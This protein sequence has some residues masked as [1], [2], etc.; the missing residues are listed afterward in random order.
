MCIA[1]WDNLSS[2][3]QLRD[4]PDRVV[5]WNRFQRDEAVRLHGMPDE[6]IV[7]T[8]A[9]SFDQWFD[10]A[11]GA[12][13][14]FCA[15]VGL[16]PN[17]PYVLF[18]GGALFPGTQT[19][20]EYVRQRLDP[21]ASRATRGWPS[22]QV[23]VRPHPRRS[24]A[25]G[26][27]ALRPTSPALPS[28]RRRIGSRCRSTRRRAPT[29]STRSPTATAVVGINTTAM[30]EAAA[31]GRR[32]VH[33]VLHPSFAD[34]QRDTYHFDYLL[35]VGGGIVRAPRRRR[36]PR[37][38]GGDRWQA[39]TTT[40]WEERRRRF[41]LEFVRPHGLDQRGAAARPR[42][43]SRKRQR[44]GPVPRPAR[45]GPACPRSGSHCRRR[46]R[47]SAALTRRLKRSRPSV[48]STLALG[49]DAASL[50]SG[51]VDPMQNEPD[52]RRDG[53][54]D[55]RDEQSEPQQPAAHAE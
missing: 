45:F 50:P 27:R 36:A 38:A 39:T 43:R 22:V 1:S 48:G 52:D 18:V 46:R 6:R 17:R 19:E 13:E 10:R 7:V 29:S 34:S 2:K 9:Q 32:S 25:V 37:A 44:F 30:I 41:L 15:R 47:A 14:E 51:S 11:P 5:V 26:G 12:R 23:L 16:D 20:A 54:N 31:V 8:G 53:R 33:T 3:Q 21:R 24:G 35:E 55:G 28:G 42:H 49:R 4:V 40:P